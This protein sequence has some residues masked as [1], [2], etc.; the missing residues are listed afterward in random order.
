M[1]NNNS[2]NLNQEFIANLAKYERDKLLNE[3]DTGNYEDSIDDENESLFSFGDNEEEMEKIIIKNNIITVSSIDRDWYN[4]NETPYK[5]NVK[6][7]GGLQ[8]NYSF[9]DYEP[10]NI[11]SIGIDKLLVNSRNINFDYTLEN[12]N[13]TNNPFLNVMINNIFRCC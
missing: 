10:K 13:I 8:N 11:I 3:N 2:F 5:F 12:R 6:L 1:D 7:G 4:N 9:I